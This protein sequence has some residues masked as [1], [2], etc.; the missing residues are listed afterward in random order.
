[1]EETYTPWKERHKDKS[2]SI[3][4][5]EQEARAACEDRLVKGETDSAKHIAGRIASR[6]R[7][8][9]TAAKRQGR[10]VQG[11]KKGKRGPD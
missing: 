1:V 7:Q 9:S 6:L 3:A 2:Y 11:E 5:D 4:S 8:S 10:E